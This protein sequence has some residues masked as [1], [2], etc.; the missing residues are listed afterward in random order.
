MISICQEYA[1]YLMKHSAF[2][3]AK[4][5]IKMEETK[6]VH[7]SLRKASGV[8]KTIQTEYVDQ[9]LEK[10]EPGSDIDPRVSNAYVLQCMAE[11]QEGK[12]FY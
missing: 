11:A 2:L 4:E 1:F 7:H 9:L 6:E 12:Q 5:D 10:P 3:A 8:L